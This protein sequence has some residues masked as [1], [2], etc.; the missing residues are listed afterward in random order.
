MWSVFLPDRKLKRLELLIELGCK[1]RPF[2]RP[3]ESDGIPED[4]NKACLMKSLHSLS[5]TSGGYALAKSTFDRL[6]KIGYRLDST[7]FVIVDEANEPELQDLDWRGS[8]TM[9]FLHGISTT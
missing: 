3:N 5:R 1:V 6:V 4:W 9:R 8:E 7:D 2:H